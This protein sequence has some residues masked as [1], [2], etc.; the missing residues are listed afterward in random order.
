MTGVGRRMR[1]GLRIASAGVIPTHDIDFLAVEFA[2]FFKVKVFGFL[3][4]R[5]KLLSQE[6]LIDQASRATVQGG[7]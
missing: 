4:E 3:K 2:G 5:V 7:R 1:M 6:E